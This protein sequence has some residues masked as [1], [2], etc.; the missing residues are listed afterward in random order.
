MSE[1]PLG[2]PDVMISF[3]GDVSMSGR[4]FWDTSSAIWGEGI[5]P[6]GQLPS[7]LHNGGIPYPWQGSRIHREGL[8]GK[9][10]VDILMSYLVLPWISVKSYRVD[11]ISSKF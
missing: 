6:S 3:P 11:D 4:Y 7:T 8:W 9:N 5:P 2:V 10:F 1:H